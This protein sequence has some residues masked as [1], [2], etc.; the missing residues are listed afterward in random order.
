MTCKHMNFAA[1]V[2]VARLNENPDG[3]VNGYMAEVRV[4]C[5]ECGQ[6]FQ[7]LGLEPGLDTQ[8]ASCS[9]DGLVANIAITPEGTKPN[10]FQR[11]A[12]NIKG[13]FQ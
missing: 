9:L 10:P 13:S 1:N 4:H 7:F 8:G 5:A 12:Y 11:M 3:S 2:S 6:K